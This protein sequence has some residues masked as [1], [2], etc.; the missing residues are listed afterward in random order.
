MEGWKEKEQR[1]NIVIARRERAYTDIVKYTGHDEKSRKA[2][3]AFK[4]MPQY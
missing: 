4:H 3:A 2:Y 1:M